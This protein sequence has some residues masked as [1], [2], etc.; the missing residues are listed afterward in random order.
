MLGS[1]AGTAASNAADRPDADTSCSTT[2]RGSAWIASGS[3]ERTS[4]AT[5]GQCEVTMLI[6]IADQRPGIEIFMLSPHLA[7]GAKLDAAIDAAM[8]KR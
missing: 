4:K 6:P 7:K 3:R 8:A 2:G 1:T 5:A